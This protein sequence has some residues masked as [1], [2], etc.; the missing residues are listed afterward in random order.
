M[1]RR[2]RMPWAT[3]VSTA[4]E[5]EREDLEQSLASTRLAIA[6]AYAGFNSSA[7]PEL[8]ESFVYEI[9]ALQ[10]RYSYLLRRRKALEPEEQR[11][12]PSATS[13]LS[14]G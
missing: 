9:R 1:I 5:T 7:D 2:A 14:V 6:Q 11:P 8:V 12:A 4:Q 10:S 3:A 13:A